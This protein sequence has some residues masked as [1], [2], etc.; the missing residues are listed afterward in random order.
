MS[1]ILDIRRAFEKKLRSIDPT[2]RT[3][4]ENVSFTPNQGEPYQ[5][6]RLL[7][8]EPDNPTFGD[9]FYR[10]VG[11]FQ[12]F[13]CYELNKGSDAAFQKATEI[14]NT[15]YRG[16]TLVEN[17]TE[18]IIRTTPQIAGGMVTSDRYVVPVIIEYFANVANV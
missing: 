7:P 12:I 13:L 4:F 8:A 17:G 1:K 11:Q 2:F 16:F 14:R 15:F 6:V 9:G 10:E 5:R 18:I 3:A